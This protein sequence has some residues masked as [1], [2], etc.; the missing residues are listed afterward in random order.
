VG[1]TEQKLISRPRIQ[2]A[3]SCLR[4]TRAEIDLE[5]IAHNFAEVRSN[6]GAEVLAVVKA[7]AYGHGVVPV[8]ERL[9]RAGAMGFAVAL[10]EEAIELRDAGVESP[11]LIL[12]GVVGGAHRE[13]LQRGIVPVVYDLGELEAFRVAA[14]DES[15]RVHLKVDTGMARLGVPLPELPAFLE[16]M[17]DMPGL[18]VSGLMT[19]LAAADADDEFTHAQL[20][21]F[22]KAIALVRAAGH[23]SFVIHAANSAA[24]FRYERSRYD[25]VRPGIALYGDAGFRTG[26][27]P[28]KPALRLRTEIISLRSLAVGDRAGYDGAFVAKRSTRLAILPIGYGDGVLRSSALGGQVLIGGQRCPYVGR[29]SMDLTH[30]DVT[31]VPAAKLGDEVVLLGTQGDET[32]RTR[33]LA[34]AAGTIPYEIM[35]SISR[36]V[37]RFYS[38]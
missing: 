8:V 29:V 25:M 10:A 18:V 6:S 9:E 11:L 37:P 19:H 22:D 7:D 14:Q 3:E 34:E 15:F 36:R 26:A 27:V 28:L 1:S 5:A 21:G 33:D 12:N 30:V 35:T 24:S 32:L 20:D 23:A 31:D 17:S 2:S 38:S 4:P 13:V 16:A